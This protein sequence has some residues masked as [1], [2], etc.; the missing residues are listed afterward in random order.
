[1]EKVYLDHNAT[2]PTDPRVIE[3]M[4]PYLKEGWGNSSSLHHFGRE[5]LQGL[6][7][8]RERIASYLN[9]RPDEIYFTSGGTESD[10]L[11]VKGIAYAQREKGRHI[12][13]SQIEH[14]AVLES[15]QF[16]EREG[17]QVTYLPVNEQRFGQS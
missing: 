6:E 4:I 10:N 9:C 16:L 12:I 3:A 8:S 1:V 2:T 5:A 15:C 17:F 7:D 14:Q 13:T 11:A